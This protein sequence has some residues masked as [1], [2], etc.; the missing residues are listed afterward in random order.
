M[1]LTPGSWLIDFVD[2]LARRL[3]LDEL[4]VQLF[5]RLR[6]V[7]DVDAADACVRVPVTTIALV[8]SKSDRAGRLGKGHPGMTMAVDAQSSAIFF[9][10]LNSPEADVAF[11]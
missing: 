7:G 3:A 4:G 8:F 1:K 10:M 6:R 2:R 11:R 9:M 5:A